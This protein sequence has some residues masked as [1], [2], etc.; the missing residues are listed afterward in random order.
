MK[1]VNFTPQAQQI[2][3]IVNATSVSGR[4][5]YVGRKA[6]GCVVA[7]VVNSPEHILDTAQALVGWRRSKLTPTLVTV[8]EARTLLQRC[9]HLKP[10]RKAG[11]DQ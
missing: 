1:D 2:E 6:C 8:E 10:K 4:T 7:C 9:V 11:R 3:P 5:A